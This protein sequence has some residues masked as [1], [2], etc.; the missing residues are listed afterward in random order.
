MHELGL[1]QSALNAAFN[2]L[3]TDERARIMAITLL[4]G[5]AACADAEVLQMGFQIMTRGTR[6]DHSQLIIK[7]VAVVCFCNRCQIEFMPEQAADLY[8]ACPTCFGFDTRV[9]QGRDIK[10]G[11]LVMWPA[12]IH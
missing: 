3:G 1:M 11:E 10:V 12:H 7:P 6:A 2:A 4:V 8:F 5:D 9:V